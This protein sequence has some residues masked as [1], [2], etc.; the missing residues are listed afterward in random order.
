MNKIKLPTGVFEYDPS[1]PLGKKGG[2]DRFFLG[3]AES[4]A[5][6]AVK[7][8]HITAAS[9]GHRELEIPQSG[10]LHRMATSALICL[11]KP[12]EA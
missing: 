8:L 3:K 6:V 5:E 1:Q 4:G 11:K 12:H 9:T 2:L 10:S 7:K